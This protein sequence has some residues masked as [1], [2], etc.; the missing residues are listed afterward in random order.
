MKKKE[1]LNLAGVV[2]VQHRARVM[3][4]THCRLVCARVH[5]MKTVRLACGYLFHLAEI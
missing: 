1:L 3:K 2:L 5:R 4:K